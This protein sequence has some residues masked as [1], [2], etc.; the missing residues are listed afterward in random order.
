MPTLT[1]LDWTIV[2]VYFIA[3]FAIAY[4]ATHG[5]HTRDSAGNYFLGGRHTGWFVI[6]ASLFASNIGSEHL[7]GLAGSGAAAGV[8][9][10]QFEVQAS[11]VL[12]ALGWFFVPFYLRSGVFTMPE[13]MERRYSAATRWYLAVISIV[14]YVLT[15]ISVTV[16][17]GG[18]IFQTL[19]G[20][21]FWTGALVVILATGVYTLLGGLRAV[22]YT[23]LLQMF[24]LIGG[25][26]TVTIA[27][28]H[29]IGGWGEMVAIA[30]PDFLTVWKP[31]SHPDYPWSG[32]LTG[33]P[34]LGV[35]YWCTDQY[36]V[37]RVLAAKN[38]DN[39]R[40]GSLM[41][42]FL[43]L[44]PI[45]IFVIPG[46][47]AYALSQQGRLALDT[48][49]SA[50]PVLI[51]TL[52]PQGLRG[53]VAAGLLAALMSSLSSVFNS[54]S[55]LVAWD[56]YKK[57]HPA[58]HDSTLVRVGQV[59]TVV[60]IGISLAWIPMMEL[61]SG[62]IFQYLQSVQSYIAPPV[63]AVFVIGLLWRRVNAHGAIVSLV[64]GFLLGAARLVAELNRDNLGDGLLFWYA[65]INFLHFG[66]LLFLACAAILIVVSL[67][68]A[69]PSSARIAGLTLQTR[70]A[71]PIHGAAED[72]PE[73]IEARPELE[74]DPVWRRRD[75][76]WSVVLAAGVVLT[77][78][79]FTG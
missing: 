37:Q 3:V 64:S 68:T 77:W 30:G 9:V 8:A 26:L 53:L 54:C 48:P 12:L 18:I 52:L 25:A 57:L 27:G 70:S 4:R 29:A 7:I 78:L 44:T 35:W 23:D 50:L 10:G 76:Q 17:A 56:I 32:I 45:F 62:Q 19:M 49:D 16:A 2:G 73:A 5:E 40:R 47:V 41:G 67:L 63:T 21:D 79:F 1:T 72:M 74:S 75:L 15:K 13:F 6:G 34:I 39:A 42:G 33:A 11:L 51:A 20:I 22:L 43:K 36:I 59:A 28:I 66:G 24:V 71:A 38:I 14:G 69:P 31:S 65:D 58:A 55:T 46:V 60:L 61:I